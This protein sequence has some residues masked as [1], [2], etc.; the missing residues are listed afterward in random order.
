[1]ARGWTQNDMAARSG[2]KAATYVLFERTGKI[3]LLRLIKV[4]EILGVA[5]QIEP[6]AAGEDY[7]Q[8]TLADLARP[9]RQRGRRASK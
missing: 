3:S 2:I 6:L 1:M 5:D 8:K 4:L 7:G 9:V